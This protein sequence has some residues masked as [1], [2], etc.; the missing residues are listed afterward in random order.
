MS[1]IV[2]PIN[3]GHSLVNSQDSHGQVSVS[4]WVTPRNRSFQ[5]KIHTRSVLTKSC[6]VH[7]LPL[8]SLCI[9]CK[10]GMLACCLC[11]G[12]GSRIQNSILHFANQYIKILT[13]CLSVYLSVCLSVCLCVCNRCLWGGT[14]L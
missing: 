2:N 10:Q 8:I 4:E 1:S 14:R 5:A 6:F 12:Q 3:A 11:R 9:L 7:T 13:M